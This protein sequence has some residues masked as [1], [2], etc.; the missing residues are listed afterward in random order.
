M[1]SCW[2]N[3]A[4]LPFAAFF[5][6]ITLLTKSFFFFLIIIIIIK[7]INRF[8]WNKKSESGIDSQK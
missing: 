2:Q 3:K 5:A 1:S 4:V 8:C 6:H 7:L